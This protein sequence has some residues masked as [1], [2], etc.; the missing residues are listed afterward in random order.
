MTIH[1]AAHANGKFDIQECY[2]R[3][4][5]AYVVKPEDFNE[6]FEA[7]KLVGSLLACD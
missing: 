2:R 1:W 6:L 3:G 4:A 5:N 7:V